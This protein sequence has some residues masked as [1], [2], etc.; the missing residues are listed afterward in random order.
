M[1]LIDSIR[2]SRKR[3]AFAK[4]LAPF[5]GPPKKG[6]PTHVKLREK[7]WVMA[8]RV[9][10]PQEVLLTKDANTFMAKNLYSDTRTKK[11]VGE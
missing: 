8:Q 2:N 1:N 5:S 9:F 11:G 4:V 6:D 3:K 10:H 7:G